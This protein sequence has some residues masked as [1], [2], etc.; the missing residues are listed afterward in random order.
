MLSMHSLL[1][2]TMGKRIYSVCNHITLMCDT[3]FLSKITFG[4]RMLQVF[5]QYVMPLTCILAAAYF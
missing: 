3:F 1:S 4:A 2:M 5:M